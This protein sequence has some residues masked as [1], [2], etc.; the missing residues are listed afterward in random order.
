MKGGTIYLHLEPSDRMEIVSGDRCSIYIRGEQTAMLFF[1][2]GADVTPIVE[3]F[4]KVMEGLAAANGVP[5]AML[6]KPASTGGEV[7]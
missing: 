7:A 3:A 1:Q 4:N 5:A 6:V 2:S